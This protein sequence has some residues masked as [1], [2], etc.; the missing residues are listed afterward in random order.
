VLVDEALVPLV[1][2]GAADGGE[3]GQEVA[4]VIR[5][6]RPGRDYQIDED[7]R[8]VHLTDEGTGAV[9]AALGG[10][11]LYTGPHLAALTRVNVALHAEALL[12]RD[13]DYRDV[14]YIVQDGRY[15]SSTRP[16]AGLPCCN[17][18]RRAA[19]GR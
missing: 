13:V 17:A 15:S 10:I 5:R 8:S 14:D 3:A 18:G 19:R 12:R 7:G 11:N 4:E 6:L 9:E 1:L 16:A 2:A